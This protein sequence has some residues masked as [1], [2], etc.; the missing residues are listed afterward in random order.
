M[1]AYRNL[2]LTPTPVKFEL[3]VEG[4]AP[5]VRTVNSR[6]GL[7]W[8]RMDSSHR[9]GNAQFTASAGEAA[10]KRV[11]QQTASD[12]CNLRIHAQPAAKGVL[13]ETEL[14]RDC[15]GN[16]VPDGTIVTFTSLD[17]NGRSTVDARVKQGIARAM[18]PAAPGAS[19]SAASGVVM[20]NEIRWGGGR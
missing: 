6:D 15:A 2:V 12:P 7:A 10:V 19:I 9:A 13:I 20:G 18:L 4:A 14:V 11:V 16:A 1:D 3:N 17:P 5:I 8:T